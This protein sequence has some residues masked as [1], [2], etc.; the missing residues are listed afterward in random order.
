LKFLHRQTWPR[1]RDRH[2][3]V[4][5]HFC[6]SL[7]DVELIEEG[8]TAYCN[9]CG[10]T[11]Y[12]NRP[13]SLERAFAFGLTGVL[14]LLGMLFLPFITMEAQ[15]NNLT[16][17]AGETVIRL[18]LTGGPIISFAVAIFIFILPFLQLA[19]LIYLCLPLLSGR[20]FP[21]MVPVTKLMQGLQSWVMVEVFFLGTLVSLLKLVKL[22][23]IT[24]G[25]GFWSMVGLML[26]LAAAVGGID[27]L[28]LWDR[29]EVAYR[30]RK[31]PD[32][33][34]EGGVEC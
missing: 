14:F 19:S 4:A 15:G 32:V 27:K 29:I 9:T 6:D 11:L 2:H 12:T 33:S 23:D 13:Q 25:L 24:L 30:R 22:A 8:Q 1:L 17:S 7:H 20:A 21:G 26:S 31:T 34:V 18:W 3:E 28:E 5:C 16:T 10:S